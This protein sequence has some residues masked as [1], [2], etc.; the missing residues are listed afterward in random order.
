[1]YSSPVRHSSAPEGL[2]PFDLHVLSMP[3]AF[4]LSQD[5]T[6]QFKLLGCF[7]Q[8]I[9]VTWATLITQDNLRRLLF[10]SSNRNASTHTN[11]FG[12][13]RF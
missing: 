3:P 8:P 13:F 6:L 12:L 5:Q 9:L 1:M 2:L 7:G 11:Y 10:C 4:N